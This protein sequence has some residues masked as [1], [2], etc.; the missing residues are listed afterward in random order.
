MLTTPWIWTKDRIGEAM[1]MLVTHKVVSATQT[2][3]YKPWSVVV[4]E[5]VGE[6]GFW[7]DLAEVNTE[8]QRGLSTEHCDDPPQTVI[9][10]SGPGVDEWFRR[11]RAQPSR[12]SSTGIEKVQLVQNP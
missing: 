3:K 7:A 9:N 6:S 11:Y 10:V 8:L 5:T 12:G 4:G 1:F 2:E